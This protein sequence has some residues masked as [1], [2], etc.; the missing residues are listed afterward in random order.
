MPER[1]LNPDKFVIKRNGEVIYDGD[2][3]HL[4][5]IGFSEISIGLT[6][7][8]L[9]AVYNQW[10]NLYLKAEVWIVISDCR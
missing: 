3:G 2:N 6:H 1:A 9:M 5:A 4:R 8:E 10:E 7:Y